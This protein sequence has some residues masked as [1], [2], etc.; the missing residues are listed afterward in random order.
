MVHTWW[1]ETVFYEL[2]MPSFC[3]AN[4]DG[5]GDFAGISQKL[6]YLAELGI[7]GIWLTPFYPS[8]KID[9]GYDVSDYCGIDSDYGTMADFVEFINKAHSLGIK[10][11]ADIVIN[12]TSDQH[13]WFIESRKAKTNPYRDY[14]IWRAKANNWESFFSGSAWEYDETTKEYYY[15]KFARE[16][17]DLNWA[18]PQI[19]IEVKKILKFWIDLGID[20]FRFDVIN[21]LTCAGIANDNPLNELGEQEHIFDINQDGIF[22]VIG[23]LCQYARS[24]GAIF[25]VGEVGS[26]QLATLKKYQGENLLDVVFDFNFGSA[27]CF[28]SKLIFNEITNME[29]ELTGLPTIFF[30]SH[31]MSRYISRFGESERDTE[32]AKAVAAL[33]L[34]LRGVPFIYFGDEIGMTDLTAT[35]LTEI[36]DIQGRNNFANA[37]LSGKSPEMALDI[38]NRNNRDKSRS[39]MQ[40]SAVT[41]AG[42]TVGNS[43][44]K[45]NPN[46]TVVNVDVE[47]TNPDSLLSYY[48]NL[49]Q[50]RQSEPCL[51]YGQYRELTYTNGL[52]KFVRSFDSTEITVYVNFDCEQRVD[53]PEGDLLL[54]KYSDSIMKNEV[55]IIRNA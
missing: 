50:I 13:P 45:I 34:C 46:H 9:N 18:N 16:Q 22:T 31:D 41:G 35:S 8:P 49:I 55:I 54:G 5:I 19:M 32:R 26:D 2:Y 14:Y 17:V 36:N 21:Y 6:G 42:F 1:K 12:H 47:L 3:D 20:G 4:G 25:T 43:W 15:H 10:V 44:L 38:A 48:K 28:N 51:Q 40:W 29:D 23:E 52:I 27:S 39:P 37:I 7:K 30:G 53:L 11:I 24:F 33:M